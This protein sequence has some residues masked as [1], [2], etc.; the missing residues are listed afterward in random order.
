MQVYIRPATKL[1]S[2]TSETYDGMRYMSIQVRYLGRIDI[3]WR[4]NYAR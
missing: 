2:V 4:R 3:Y 1:C